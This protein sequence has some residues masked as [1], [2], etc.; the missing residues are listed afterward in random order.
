MYIGSSSCYSQLCL[1]HRA[2]TGTLGPYSHLKTSLNGHTRSLGR[3]LQRHQ[4]SPTKAGARKLTP[5]ATGASISGSQPL[6]QPGRVQNKA[7]SADNPLLRVVSGVFL[8][9][10]GSF[11]IY[12]GG[13]LFTGKSRDFALRQRLFLGFKPSSAEA[14]EI[15]RPSMLLLVPS[16]SGMP[17]Y[18][19]DL[20]KAL[21][22]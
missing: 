5:Q 2:L 22:F 10:L 9:A 3:P 14:S 8:G 13:L 4:S 18:T 11:A 7:V 6:Q 15:C 1:G 17:S 19:S 21:F 12:A 20:Q 16:V